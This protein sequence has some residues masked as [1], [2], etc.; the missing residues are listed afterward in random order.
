MN[1]KIEISPK[2]I[3]FTVFFL[4]SLYLVYIL[5]ELLI[6]LFISVLLTTALNP[7]VNKLEKYKVP[8]GLGIL[9]VYILLII[10]F[11]FTIS[12]IV[13]PLVTQTNNLL[14]TLP[15]QNL[16][17]KLQPVEVNLE[18]LQLITNQLGSFAPVV[19]FITGTFSAIITLFTFLVITFY[20]LM[21][22]K[23]LHK[24]LVF[25]FGKDADAGKAENFLEE[26][27]K[28]IGGWVRGEFFLMVII[29]V[30]TYIGL[31][32]L[33]VP[34]ALALAIIAGILELVPNIGP[35]IS[36][37]PAILIAAI[38]TQ[39]PLMAFFVAVLYLVIQQLENNFIVPKVMQ[40]AVGIHPLVTILLIIVGLK[41]AGIA[42]AVL[43][44]PA[45]LVVKVVY[46]ELKP[47]VKIF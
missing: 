26:V 22:R 10:F 28:Q 42:G 20:M 43:A 11:V 29:G 3:I 47:H 38:A 45:F 13:P 32:L 2:T 37:I 4:L 23:H 6:G 16:S 40:T 18:S 15:L 8:R 27:D 7:V 21:E 34:Y 5:R 41:L 17:K 31:T 25:I 39:N 35:I 46:K 33:G 9:M 44:V 12:I 24:H 19:K 14:E 30:A 36:A 1:R